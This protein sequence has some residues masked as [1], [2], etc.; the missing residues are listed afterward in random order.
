MNTRLIVA[1]SLL[2][3]GNVQAAIAHEGGEH[4]AVLTARKAATLDPNTF[5]VGHPASP[6]AGT[7]H[8]GSEHPAVAARLAR[9]AGAIDPNR[10]RVQPPASVQ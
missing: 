5:I 1:L 9:R 2:A 7:V 4:P 6:R 8:A 10:F 3:L